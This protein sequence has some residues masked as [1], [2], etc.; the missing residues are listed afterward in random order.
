VT[1]VNSAYWKFQDAV[2][3]GANDALR[4]QAKYERVL[5]KYVDRAVPFL[6]ATAGDVVDI[7]QVTSSYLSMSASQGTY[8]AAYN[9]LYPFIGTG[10]AEEAALGDAAA[11]AFSDAIPDVEGFVSTLQDIAAGGGVA[12]V[13]AWYFLWWF[14]D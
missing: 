5:K 4:L 14:G 1:K 10:T 7:Y 6:S 13:V 12:G 8:Q 2:L 9:A 3:S 11:Q